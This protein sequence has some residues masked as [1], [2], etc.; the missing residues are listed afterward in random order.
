MRKIEK[1]Y[2][3]RASEYIELVMA[4]GEKIELTNEN[5]SLVFEND[6]RELNEIIAEQKKLGRNLNE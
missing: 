6:E 4:N 3:D 1:I 2:I 5:T